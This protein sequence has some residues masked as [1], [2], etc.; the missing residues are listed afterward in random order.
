[1]TIKQICIALALPGLLLFSAFAAHGDTWNFAGSRHQAMG[2]TGVAFSDDSLSAYWNP[3][4]LAF[5]K[6][7]DVQLPVTANGEIVSHAVERLS[8]LLQDASDLEGLLNSY[9]DCTGVDCQLDPL[10]QDQTNQIV[11]FISDLSDFGNQAES[12]HLDVDIGILGRYNNFAFSALSFTTATVYPNIDTQRVRVGANP[13]AWIPCPPQPPGSGLCNTP[14][15][16]LLQNSIEGQL[17]PGSPWSS[18]QIGQLIWLAEDG[19]SQNPLT[20]DERDILTRVVVEDN[21][22]NLFTNN[23]SGAL[24]AGLS[25]QEFGISWSHK[26]P[27]PGYKK[28]TGKTKALFSYLHEKV[29]LGITPKYILG[30][31]FINFYSYGDGDTISNV[32]DTLSDLNNREMTHNFGLDVGLSLRPVEWLQIGFI[33]RNVNSP[34]FDVQSFKTV[35]DRTIDSIELEAQ[36]RMGVALLPIKNMILSADIDLTENGITT[37]PGFKSRLLSVGA[38]YRIGMGQSVDL[39][40]RLGTF[41]NLASSQI[42]NWSM[43]G[44]LGLRL[45]AFVLD[46]SAGGT[47]SDEIVRTGRNSY[48]DLPTGLNLGLGFK[49]QKSL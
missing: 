37:V 28:M 48:R 47:F 31:T 25:T 40:L 8:N 45:G 7:W 33:G 5:Q 39:N 34:S 21:E 2:G 36:V 9:I 24:A 38:E 49:W 42:N 27:V 3:A 35:N 18:D 12:V 13:D 46:L 4:N 32:V 20:Q 23:Q 41:G 26:L 29:S 1:M 10:S 22:E 6:G 14:A 44:G 43:T 11:G 30:I 17:P 19:D 15:D 16:T